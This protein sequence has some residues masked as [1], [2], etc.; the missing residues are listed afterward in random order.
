MVGLSKSPEDYA[1]RGFTPDKQ[2]AAFRRIARDHGMPIDTEERPRMAATVPAC[3]AVV[4]ARERS[5]EHARP[6]LRRLR[7]LNFAGWLL[8][9]PETVDRAARE[10]G[11]DPERLREWMAEPEVEAALREDM[12]DGAASRCPPHGCS[13]T[14]SPTGR[15]GAATPARAMR[16]PGS[17]TG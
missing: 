10:S 3:R 6:L 5:P 13:T 11:L 7:V 2:A 16:S 15:A 8:D 12:D 9:E 17:P 4:A 1:E 14:S